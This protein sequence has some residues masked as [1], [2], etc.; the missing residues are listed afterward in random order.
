MHLLQT[1]IPW[2]V[3]APGEAWRGL[4][5]PYGCQG[6][7]LLRP[8]CP[9][10]FFAS[11]LPAGKAGPNISPSAD[12]VSL[13][14]TQLLLWRISLVLTLGFSWLPANVYK[15]YQLINDTMLPL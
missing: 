14:S 8:P 6:R 13:F 15:M 5:F 3:E 9:L 10:A 12:T 7:D 1:S 2:D 4:W 11:P